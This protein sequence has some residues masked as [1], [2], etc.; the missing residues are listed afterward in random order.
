MKY[1]HEYNK[2]DIRSDKITRELFEKYTK[3]TKCD[4]VYIDSFNID[5]ISQFV[6][7]NDIVL[8]GIKDMFCINVKHNIYFD[9]NLYNGMFY[10]EHV[11]SN[12][13]NAHPKRHFIIIGEYHSPEKLEL[14]KIANVDVIFW[15]SLLDYANYAELTPV[16]NK[17]FSSKYTN[18]ALNRRMD[19]HRL[20]LVGYLR[21]SKLH[22]N[23]YISALLLDEKCENSNDI[24]DLVDW[25][26]SQSTDHLKNVARAGYNQLCKC[27]NLIIQEPYSTLPD[28]DSVT[29][30]YNKENFE[31]NLSMLYKNSFV[32]IVT[33][34]L[35]AFHTGTVTEKYLNSIFGMNYPI[36]LATPGTVAYL[37]TAGFDMFDD[38]I[39]HAYDIVQDPALR[40]QTAIVD[41]EQILSNPELA[42]DMWKSHRSRFTKNV[43]YFKTVFLSSHIAEIEAQISKTIRNL[44]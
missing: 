7:E 19:M 27:N 33:E 20:M 5:K 9:T 28:S 8:I 21:G 40:L 42:K 43:N 26:F 31:L 6:F 44:S 1:I 16:A 29:H 11:L 38:V 15:S 39:N 25:E 14:N 23:A 12:I 4:S 37:R 17:N 32:E 22:K 3:M 30:W 10:A 34:T 2:V 41:N 24:M 35:F 18:I 36:I 13:A